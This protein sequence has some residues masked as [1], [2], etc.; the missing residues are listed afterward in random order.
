MK[1]DCEDSNKK[2]E[3]YQSKSGSASLQMFGCSCQ[4]TCFLDL[5]I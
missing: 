1:D 2:S 4:I 3:E 5:K